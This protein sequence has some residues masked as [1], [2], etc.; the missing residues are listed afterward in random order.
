VIEAGPGSSV[1]VNG[2]GWCRPA[3][4]L[5]VLLGVSA[6]GASY[7][8]PNVINT[9]NGIALGSTYPDPYFGVDGTGQ[10]YAFHGSGIT[11][12]F[13]DGSARYLSSNIDVR[14]YAGLISRNGSEIIKDIEP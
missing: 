1:R 4:E 2:G 8:G 3:S 9:T 13:V 14:V 6:D 5:N 11:A 7:P 12:V 10:A